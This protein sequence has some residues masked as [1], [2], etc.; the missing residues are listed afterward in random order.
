[1]KSSIHTEKY[2]L[3]LEELKD[4]RAQA[5]LSQTELA[6]RLDVGQ[7]LISRSEAGSRRVDVF[8]LAL[9]AHACG[10]TLEAFVQRL[11]ERIRS[12]QLPGLL[13]EAGQGAGH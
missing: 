12:N 13:G 10:T 9:W 3:F 11:D 5:G 2:A 4:L 1:M 7:D 6:T 8:E